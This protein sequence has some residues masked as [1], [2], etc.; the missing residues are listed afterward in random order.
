M[1]LHHPWWWWGI[2]EKMWRAAGRGWEPK[3]VPYRANK[4]KAAACVSVRLSW[5]R[6]PLG[7]RPFW[8]TG[9][10]QPVTQHCADS[11]S[12][13]GPAL[14]IFRSKVTRGPSHPRDIPP[15]RLLPQGLGTQARA[16]TSASLGTASPSSPKRPPVLNDMWRM[17]QSRPCSSDTT[18][19][20]RRR[21]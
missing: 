20:W 18:R 19:S 2:M 10:V 4:A 15:S 17:H 8:L 16:W 13:C 14:H 11:V 3:S 21:D 5:G 6:R 9:A 7:K 12:G 1:C